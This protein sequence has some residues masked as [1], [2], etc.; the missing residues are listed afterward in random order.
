MRARLSSTI[1]L[2][3]LLVPCAGSA[4]TA[5][6]RESYS[7][8]TGRLPYQTNQKG[9]AGQEWHLHRLDTR[10]VTSFTVTFQT[11]APNLRVGVTAQPVDRNGRPLPNTVWVEKTT[12]GNLPGLRNYVLK[13]TAP[14]GTRFTKATISVN[15]Q[16]RKRRAF[17]IL[18]AQ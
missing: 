5:G 2:L 14:A 15:N 6:R 3:V 13:V 10:R 11:R 16:L 7:I 18:Q 17:Y 1:C 8:Y 9:L 12:P 4:P